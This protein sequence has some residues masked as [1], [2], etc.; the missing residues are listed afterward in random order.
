MEVYTL[1]SR[2]CEAFAKYGILAPPRV[3]LPP[4]VEISAGGVPVPP[5]PVR[6]DLAAAIEE[7]RRCLWE[8]KRAMARY[9]PDIG[10]WKRRFRG[11]RAAA[12]N[13]SVAEREPTP[14]D[15]KSTRLNSSHRSLSRM[16][17]SA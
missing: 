4:W 10:Y 12:I 7:R 9:A 11:E 3:R 16:P 15:R 6:E 17:S 13:M 2:D 8:Q 14:P 1:W 5:I